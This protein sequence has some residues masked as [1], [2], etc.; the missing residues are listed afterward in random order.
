MPLVVALPFASLL[1]A[2]GGLFKL[3]ASLKI[4]KRSQVKAGSHR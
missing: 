2:I 1:A 4:G 3:A